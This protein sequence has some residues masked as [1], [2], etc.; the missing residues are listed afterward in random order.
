MFMALVATEAQG[1]VSHLSPGWR[2]RDR[3]HAELSDL[4]CYSMLW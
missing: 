1:Q 2:S 4:H 3:M